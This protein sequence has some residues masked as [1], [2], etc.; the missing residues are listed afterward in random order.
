MLQVPPQKDKQTNKHLYCAVLMAK[1]L[2]SSWTM[3]TRATTGTANPRVDRSLSF[4]TQTGTGTASGFDFL[5]FK[6][7]LFCNL[8]HTHSWIHP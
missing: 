5:V 7:M 1:T 2:A 4:R 3:K 8:R 6:T